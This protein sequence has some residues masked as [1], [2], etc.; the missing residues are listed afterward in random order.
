MEA[1]RDAGRQFDA[2]DFGAAYVGSVENDDVAAVGGR[3][4]DGGQDP[5]FVLGGATGAADED[6][7]TGTTASAVLVHLAGAC[8]EIMLDRVAERPLIEAGAHSRGVTETVLLVQYRT[9]DTG[10]LL[11]TLVD[12]VSGDLAGLGVNRP[13]FELRERVAERAIAIVVEQLVVAADVDDDPAV[14][15]VIAVQR[16]E[17]V[18][19]ADAAPDDFG[20][21]RCAAR[22]QSNTSVVVVEPSQRE[23]G[24]AKGEIKIDRNRQVEHDGVLLSQ[25][26]VVH[27][28]HGG[29]ADLQ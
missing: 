20:F 12:D 1:V 27:H 11:E 26:H 17:G 6:G 25:T 14:V 21:C 10:E 3:V 22:Q 9:C 5:A 4:I 29:R 18:T 2:G 23:R 7:L 19:R 8:V 24:A 15:Q 16:M 13:A 28:W